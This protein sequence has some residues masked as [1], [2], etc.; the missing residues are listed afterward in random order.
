M[1][2]VDTPARLLPMSPARPGLRIVAYGRRDGTSGTRRLIRGDDG[3][4]PPAPRLRAVAFDMG[5]GRCVRAPV[6][7]GEAIGI[8][9]IE[10]ASDWLVGGE[11]RSEDSFELGALSSILRRYT[12]V[13]AQQTSDMGR[14]NNY[15]AYTVIGKVAV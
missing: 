6:V 4:T 11:F 10:G 1:L 8:V 3:S 12:A 7:R 5:N 2:S 9:A 15:H 14:L 13:D